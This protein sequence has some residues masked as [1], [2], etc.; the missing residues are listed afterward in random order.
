M[1]ILIT[2]GF[3]FIGGRLAQ[4]L[5]QGG[6]DVLLGSRSTIASAN[7]LPQAEVVQTDWSDGSSLEQICKDVDVVIHAAGMNAGDCT[8]GPVAALECNGLFTARLV[9]AAVCARV[10]RFIYLS[11]AHVYASHLVGSIT[12]ETC[13][14]NLHP[15][16]TSH[17]A[18]ENAV[19]SANVRGEIEGIV[20]RLS[21]AFGAPVHKDVNCWMLLVNDLCWQAVS[22]K[23]MVLRTSGVQQRDFI[24]LTD[25]GM[26]IKHLLALGQEQCA[27]GLFNLGSSVSM[28]VLEMTKVIASRCNMVLGFYPEIVL[29]SNLPLRSG[30][31][32]VLPLH[33]NSDKFK[34][35][36]FHLKG[37]IEGEI[38][39]ILTMCLNI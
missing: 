35:T 20:L 21:N 32:Q 10:K 2:G 33:Y 34:S 12:E 26:A 29:P 16:A 3:G 13:P 31:E 17:L 15:Y 14:R 4:H 11:T 9:R 19:L 28:A 18:G 30:D 6:H 38:D 37:A 22:S 5:Q 39:G 23:K 25:V 24:P 36:G 27:D 7:W 8:A 1:R